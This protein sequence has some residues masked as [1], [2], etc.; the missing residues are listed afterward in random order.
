MGVPL[1]QEELD[2]ISRATAGMNL[3]GAQ[4]GNQRDF[5][6]CNLARDRISAARRRK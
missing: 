6:F 5:P 3:D 2:E 4:L 1:S